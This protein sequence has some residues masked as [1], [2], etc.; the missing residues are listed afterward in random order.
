VTRGAAIPALPV[1][2]RPRERLAALGAAALSDAELVAIHL[3]TGATGESALSLAQALLAEWG[4]VAGLARAAADELARRRGVGPAKAARLVAAFALADRVGGASRAL[5]LRTSADVAAVAAP[6]IGRE[7][8]E[9]VVLMVTDHGQR[10]TRALT[11]ARGGANGCAVPVREILSLVLRHDGVAFA[12]AHNHPGGALH[13]SRADL[14]VTARLRAAAR[15]LDL[16]LLDH[17]IIADGAWRSVT[18]PA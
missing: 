2:D 8:V 4:G 9:H 14:A 10:L 13:P 6:I 12:L 1:H 7:R 3:G 18:A 15:T 17:V 16:R 11:V 5:V